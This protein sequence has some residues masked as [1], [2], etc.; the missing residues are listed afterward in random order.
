MLK[1]RRPDLRRQQCLMVGPLAILLIAG[2]GVP[3]ALALTSAN[4]SSPSTSALLV[5]APALSA[6][7]AAAPPL[8]VLNP[9]DAERYIQAF[10]AMRRGDI[11]AGQSA[12][13][14]VSDPILMGWL[15]TVRLL[16][17]AY[18]AGYPELRAWLD[19]NIDLPAAERVYDLALKRK[20]F[21]APMPRKP[22]SEEAEAGGANLAPSMPDLTPPPL[23]KAANARQQAARTAFY[24]GD[25]ATAL[26]LANASGERWIAGLSA[27]RLHLYDAALSSLS[28]MAHDLR[29]T[30]WARSGAAYWAARAA[31]ALNQPA[32]AHAYM[33]LAAR[34][35]ETFYGLIA[36]RDLDQQ[37]AKS[38]LQADMINDVLAAA[39]VDSAAVTQIAHADPRA[40]RAVALAQIGLLGEAGEDLRLALEEAPAAERPALTSLALALNAPIGGRAEVAKSGWARFDLSHFPT[41]DLTPK[42]GFTIDKALVYA[43]VNQESRFNPDVVSHA[44]AYGLMQL[45]AATAARLAGDKS[46][47]RHPSALR[48]P[49]FNLRLGQDYVAKLLSDLNGDIMQ[50]VAAYNAGPGVIQKLTARMGQDVDSLMLIESMPSS[51]TRGYVQRVMAGYWTYRQIFSQAPHAK[52]TQAIDAKVATSTASIS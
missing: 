44:G 49:G 8:A 28:E 7:P 1:T 46:L 27:M 16:H 45:T 11:A 9:V 17:P 5:Q 37:A 21:G 52:T 3:Q 15:D 13:R 23:P 38:A 29:Q 36:L 20:P 34:A 42:G 18:R 50:A 30:S 39:A 33:T 35:P 32:Q 31:A 14:G 12:V 26:T 10:A 22:S 4:T 19:R 51:Q 24:K 41:P 25:I 43:L 47:R 2:L 40:R 6:S 48:D